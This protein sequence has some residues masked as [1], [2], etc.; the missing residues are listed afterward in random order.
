[1]NWVDKDTA[2]GSDGTIYAI[3]PRGIVEVS[4]DNWRAK[5]SPDG[6]PKYPNRTLDLKSKIRA[7]RIVKLIDNLVLKNQV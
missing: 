2:V 1:M 4:G 6:T 3:R 5:L 7:R